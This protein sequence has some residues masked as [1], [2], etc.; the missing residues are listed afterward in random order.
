MDTMQNKGNYIIRCPECILIPSIK[1]KF[2]N[3]EIEYECENKHK[4]TLS[5]DKFIN[6]SKKYSLNKTKCLNYS[7]N[8]SNNKINLYFFKCKNFICGKC[9]NE[10]SK[11]KEHEFYISITRFDRYCKEH[12]NSYSYYCKIVKKIYVLF[13]VVSI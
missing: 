3:N 11:N 10:H 2:K 9:F 6:E 7:N 8:E 1:M 12:N 4:N 5:Y 13:A